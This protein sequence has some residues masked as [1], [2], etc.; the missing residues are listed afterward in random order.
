M[1]EKRGVHAPY[2][3]VPF[4]S[5]NNSGTNICSGKSRVERV[6]I[7]YGNAEDLPRHDSIDP[8]LKTGEIHVTMTAETPVFVSDGNEHFFRGPN[9]QLMLPGSTIRGMARENM[10]I[11]GFGLIQPEEDLENYQIYFREMAAARESAANPLKQYYQGALGIETGKDTAGKSF[12]V[13][14][15]VKTGYLRQAGKSLCIQP[16]KDSYLRVPR[17][18]PALTAAGLSEGEAK[19]VPVAYIAEGGRVKELRRS[20]DP[21]PGMEHGVLLYTGKAVGNKPNARYLFP[22]ADETAAPV[23]I[24]EVD[25]FSYAEDFEVRRNVLGKEKARFW[26]LPD[27][28][29]E[30]PVFYIQ[31]NGHTY[32]GMSLF[33][34][35]GYSH[36]LSEGLPGP[37]T[38]RCIGS[39]PL[40]YIH[41][42]LGF[43]ED[44]GSYRSRVSFGDFAAQGDPRESAPVRTILGQPKPSWYTGYVVNGEHYNADEFYLRGFKLYWLKDAKAPP[45][46][47]GKERVGSALRPLPAGTVFRGVIRY[48]NLHEDELGLLLWALRL[49]EG[50]Y[51]SIGMGKPYGFGRM[52]LTIDSLREYDMKALYK[53]DG[54]CNGP[55][56]VNDEQVD[57]YIQ[58][59]DAWVSEQLRVKKPKKAPSI[60]SL[61]AIQDFFFMHR[62]LR[63]G[64]DTSY[65]DLSEYKNLTAVL[66]DVKTVREKAEKSDNLAA[67]APE[68]PY[69]ALRRKF[70]RL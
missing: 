7:R 18:N 34:R 30:K 29:E 24:S 66:P 64:L 69:E 45:V 70:G 6:L 43:A 23:R 39:T 28:G 67:Q 47:E 48:K 2:N 22:A 17:S 41:A 53:P 21:V 40:D 35:I 54:L 50:C 38:E 42:V 12:S 59:Y 52:K 56:A 61:D 58:K 68:D 20:A 3:F 31:R 32:F 44:K 51:Q 25:W 13:P 60:R 16:T 65:M 8:V 37:Q 49:E 4:H 63:C 55:I 26:A 5:K 15:D 62:P 11:L 19:T 14:K 10:Q 46:P 33:L 1:S 27:E 9:G 57:Q 36:T